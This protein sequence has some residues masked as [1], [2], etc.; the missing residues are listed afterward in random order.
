MQIHIKTDTVSGPSPNSDN[1]IYE[2][3]DGELWLQLFDSG[4]HRLKNYIW[5]GSFINAWKCVPNTNIAP[6]L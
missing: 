4:K 3:N 2:Q 5:G 1:A 6:T